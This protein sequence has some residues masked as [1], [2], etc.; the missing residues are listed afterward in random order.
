MKD[1]KKFIRIMCLILVAV[2]VLDL[3]PAIVFAAGG[4]QTVLLTNTAGW[5]TPYIYFWSDSNTGMTSWPGQPM[6][7]LEGNI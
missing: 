6:S 1:P 5:N 4:Q 2:M 7:L 3:I